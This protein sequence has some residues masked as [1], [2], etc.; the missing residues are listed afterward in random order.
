MHDAIRIVA[1]KPVE[2]K[3]VNVDECKAKLNASTTLLELQTNW[4]SLTQQEQ[5]N[6]EI[7]ALKDQLKTTLK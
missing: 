2:Q 4:S 7:L 3:T 1:N 5:A 6:T